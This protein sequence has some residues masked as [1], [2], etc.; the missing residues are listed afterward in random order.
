MT[1]KLHAKPLTP[2]F[3][4]HAAFL[5]LHD[6]IGR[7]YM[8]HVKDIDVMQIDRDGDIVFYKNDQSYKY[9]RANMSVVHHFYMRA[10]ALGESYDLRPICNLPEEDPLYENNL[11]ADAPLEVKQAL[12]A[13]VKPYR[14]GEF[15]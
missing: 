5:L 1:L 3:Q 7:T 9:F 6:Q 10:R 13:R 14:L 15:I 12:A 2:A 4:N 11:D 8:I